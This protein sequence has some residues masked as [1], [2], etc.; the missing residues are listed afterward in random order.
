M[1][2]RPDILHAPWIPEHPVE[3]KI[4]LSI[5]HYKDF[6]PRQIYCVFGTLCI[7]AAIHV[8]FLFQETVGKTL[9][10]ID[11]IFENQSVWAFKAR[12]EPSRLTADIEQAKE[13]IGV[14]KVGVSHIEASKP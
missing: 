2:L 10:E 5:L 11:E 6:N 7:V 4:I 1:Q 9:E 13:N 12:Q 8:F 3:G 14:G